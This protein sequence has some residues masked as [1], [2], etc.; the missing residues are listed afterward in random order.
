MFSVLLCGCV[1][2]N[3]ALEKR[4]EESSALDRWLGMSSVHGGRFPL[5]NLG[6]QNKLDHSQCAPQTNYSTIF[7]TISSSLNVYL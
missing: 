2:V 3:D 5:R 4:R 7:Q 1:G 6:G